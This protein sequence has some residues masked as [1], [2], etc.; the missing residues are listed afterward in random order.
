MPRPLE[1]DAELLE[2]FRAKAADM[3]LKAID[4][5]NRRGLIAINYQQHTAVRCTFHDGT[6]ITLPRRLE[7]HF[8]RQVFKLRPSRDNA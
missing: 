8:D 5:L 1:A 2:R 7:R 3:E 4:F 6:V